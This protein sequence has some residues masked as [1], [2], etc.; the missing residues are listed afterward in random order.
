MAEKIE[1]MED[2]VIPVSLPMQRRR[3]KLACGDFAE[4]GEGFFKQ[5][6]RANI[7]GA[8]GIEN[9]A[10]MQAHFFPLALARQAFNRWLR[11]VAVERQGQGHKWGGVI[12]R[13][14]QNI[15]LLER[16]CGELR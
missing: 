8:G 14:A 13:N 7:R 4:T 5:S 9:K 11:R 2:I 6:P 3:L 12:G 1:R 16:C 10:I 15:N